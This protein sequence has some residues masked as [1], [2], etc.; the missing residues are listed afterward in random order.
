VKS[1]NM[2]RGRPVPAHPH[3]RKLEWVAWVLG[4][5]PA[6]FV[7]SPQT[8]YL[9]HSLIFER[10]IHKSVLN[11]DPSRVGAGKITDELLVGKRILERIIGQN[12]QKKLRLWFQACTR[13]FLGV[14]LRLFREDEEVFH[15]SSFLAHAATGVAS[16]ERME[17]RIPG[18]E[19]KYRLS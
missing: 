14:L 16:P 10:L 7:V 12:I 15:Q 8:Q 4:K 18:I 6:L 11:I 1:G 5:Q 13:K 9:H 17:S 19:T 2:E 3:K